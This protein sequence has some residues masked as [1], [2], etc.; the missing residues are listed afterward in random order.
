LEERLRRDGAGSI[1]DE[2]RAIDPV[3]ADRAQRNPRRMIRALEIYAVTGQPPSRARR[4]SPP[5]WDVTAIGLEVPL[6]ELDRRI[7][8]R[9]LQMVESGFVKEVAALGRDYPGAD[10]R[11]L[12]HGY[13]EIAAHL[14]GKLSLAAA[15]EAT[16][17]Q[18]RQ[19]ARRQYTWF[20]A[21]P[22]VRWI[23]PDL[24]AAAQLLREAMMGQEAS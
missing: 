11:R 17:L 2:L 18:V 14:E 15:V 10:F 9:V 6:K 7:E 22:R 3:A 23:P 19:Y 4:A 24:D 13:P 21:D 12:G 5:G 16:V 20:R 8:Q 1:D